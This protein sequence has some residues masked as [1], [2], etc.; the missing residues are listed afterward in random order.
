MKKLLEK[1]D[2]LAGIFAIVA[3]V[4]I[5]C[6]VSFGGFTKESI[7]GGIKDITG[8][9]VDV[10]VFVV[11]ASVLLRKP[12]DFREKFRK[13]MNK[14]A[15]KYSPL[16]VEDKKEGCIRYNIASNSDALFT[17]ETKK[18]ERIFELV[19]NKPKEIC[20]YINKSFFDKTGGIDYDPKSIAE[21]IEKR[22]KSYCKDFII[23]SKPNGTN[24]ML[25][26]KFDHS[27]ISNDDIDMLIDLIDYT[28][29]LFVARNKS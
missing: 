17:G 24:Y 28:V 22:L 21:D 3:V 20:F 4:A 11:A 23:S 16:L 18:P 29:L 10:L 8:I 7:V 19:E 15:E 1:T 12:M 14:I 27:I 9:I 6:E 2:L 5:I 26:I 13:E 25:S